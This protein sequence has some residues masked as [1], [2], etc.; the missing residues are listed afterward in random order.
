MG[1]LLCSRVW[2]VANVMQGVSTP[3]L[4]HGPRKCEFSSVLGSLV[5]RTTCLKQCRQP[6]CDSY[7][8]AS[9]TAFLL[10]NMDISSCSFSWTHACVISSGHA[11]LPISL[12]HIKS[13]ETEPTP[14]QSLCQSSEQLSTLKSVFY[15][16][17]RT[18]FKHLF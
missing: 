2:A 7:C 10:S 16:K 18:S 12:A 9:S 15:I 5:P 4:A 8:F 3:S 13:I 1:C 11:P 17:A 14:L 6:L